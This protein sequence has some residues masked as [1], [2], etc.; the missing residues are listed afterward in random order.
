MTESKTRVYE[1]TSLGVPP[2]K[3]VLVHA[4]NDAQN[5]AARAQEQV[6]EAALARQSAPVDKE[7]AVRKIIQ[8]LESADR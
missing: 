8:L 2:L 4:R 7:A 6:V 5:A 3:M 1:S